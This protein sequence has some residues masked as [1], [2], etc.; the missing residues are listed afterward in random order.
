MSLYMADIGLGCTI[1]SPVVTTLLTNYGWG[2][3]YVIMDAIILVFALP[4]SLFILRKSPKYIGLESYE[5]G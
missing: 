2:I 4:I 5:A 3:T 1:F